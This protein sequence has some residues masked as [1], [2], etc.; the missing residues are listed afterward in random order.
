MQKALSRKERRN[1]RKE[2]RQARRE[3]KMKNN[4]YKFPDV[5]ESVNVSIKRTV[6]AK[7]KQQANV[8]NAFENFNIVAVT[9]TVG[10]GKTFLAAAK[11]AEMLLDPSN[12]ID[13]I[14]LV[15][16]NEPLGPS[17][18]HLPGD[19]FE[20]LKPYLEPI[21]AGLEHIMGPMAV[22]KLIEQEKIQYVATQHLRGRTWN[23]KFVIIDECNNLSRRATA[24][25]LLRKGEDTKLAFCGDE[26]Q[27]DVHDNGMELLKQIK[28]SYQNAPLKYCELVE[29]V[30]SK[31]AAYFHQIFTEM[32]VQY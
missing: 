29:V 30:R 14:I 15:R 27:A 23:N 13:G 31:E 5:H 12:P 17:V 20:K 22:K 11:A 18:G 10:S 1:Q 7:N 4:V 21:L 26:L 16:A 8:L 19:L 32:G 6:R 2:E 24:V 3:A 25:A 28:M 9:G